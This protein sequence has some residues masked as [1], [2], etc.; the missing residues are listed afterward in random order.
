MGGL[1]LRGGKGKEGRRRRGGGDGKK[2]EGGERRRGE[3]RG[4]EKGVRF[5]FSADLATLF[6][7]HSVD[8]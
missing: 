7:G 6:E 8:T 4:E 2:G 5:F 3:G 1:P